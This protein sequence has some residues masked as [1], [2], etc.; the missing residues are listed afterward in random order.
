MFFTRL[1][2]QQRLSAPLIQLA[3]VAAIIA[4]VALPSSGQAQVQPTTRIRIRTA[5]GAPVAG[6]LVGLLDASG[7]IVVE[8]LSNAEGARSLSAP[9]G[10]YRVQVR[11]IGFEPFISEPM[12]FPRSGDLVLPITD[13]A[14]SLQTVVVTA[15][16]RCRSIETDA[17]ALATVWE[18]IAKAL[19]A[20][21]LT[22]GDLAGI[23][24][25]RTYR[26]DVG[27]RGKLISSV[28]N[29]F[30]VQNA[31]PFGTI[32]PRVLAIAGYVQGNV[33]DGWEYY[34]PD[35]AV[36]LS[37]AF[38]STHC[39]RVVRDKK[40]PGL[41][42]VSF[43]PVAGRRQSDIAGVLWVQEKT[44]ELRE[45]T[46]KFVNVDVI[47]RFDAGGR[48]HFRRMPSGAWLV[49]EWSLRFPKLEVK[50]SGE[51]F[52]EIGFVENGGG[53]IQDAIPQNNGSS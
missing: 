32:D 38:A 39:F 45:M 4:C 42:G 37:D 3:L 51:T 25:F 17:A 47:S 22:M 13:R 28:T 20:S 50:E 21:Q 19:R 52:V 7:K 41:I 11:R 16:A 26:K 44:S 46:F 33:T 1:F 8:G 30:K 23:G 5:D 35:E 29:V 49:D 12:A 43:E 18:E 48:T 40:R 53:I 6:A 10:T 2:N 24:Q 31:R 9:E 34:A 36:L 15:G 14:V 27:P